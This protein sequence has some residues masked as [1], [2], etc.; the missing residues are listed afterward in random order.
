M[1][2]SSSQESSAAFGSLSFT[3]ASSSSQSSFNSSFWW[4]YIHTGFWEEY[5]DDYAQGYYLVDGG[6]WHIVTVV[7]VYLYF[8]LVYGPRMMK[9]RPAYDLKNVL[10]YYNL[11]HIIGNG[12]CSVTALYLTRMTLDCWSSRRTGDKDN[13]E[14]RVLLYLA[15]AYFCCKFVDLFDTVFFILRK[16]DKQVSFLHVVHH[17]VMPLCTYCALR[18]API[19]RTH[20]VGILN[21][22]VHTIMYT[23]YFLSAMPSMQQHLWWKKYITGMQILQFVIFTTHSLQGIFFIDH[24]EFPLGMSILTLLNA[25]FFLTTFIDFFFKTYTKKPMLDKKTADKEPEVTK[26]LQVLRE[27]EV[28]IK[29]L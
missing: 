1:M 18:F 22:V 21:S 3:S 9:N 19:G 2:T 4:E 12:V 11:F 17:S 27:E 25:M 5:G 23:Y 10:Y 28:K 7:A 8:V 26:T 29:S 13:V 16:K 24:N 20:I 15:L 6:P 14:H